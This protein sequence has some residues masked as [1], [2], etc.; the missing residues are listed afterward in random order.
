MANVM[1]NL[2]TSFYTVK[3]ETFYSIYL[4]KRLN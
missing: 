4:L 3:M 1:A 2:F